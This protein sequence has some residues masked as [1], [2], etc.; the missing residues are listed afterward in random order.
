MTIDRVHVGNQP[1][2]YCLLQRSATR[3]RVERTFGTSF[4]PEMCVTGLRIVTKNE[5]ALSANVATRG[6]MITMALTMTRAPPS[7]GGCNEGGIK[8]FSHD[9][10]RVC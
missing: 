9:L 2:A 3:V 7:A 4:I 10:R 6:T 1:V 8:H 5:I